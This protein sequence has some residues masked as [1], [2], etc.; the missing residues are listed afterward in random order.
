MCDLGIVPLPNIPDWRYQCPLK[1]IEYLS[2]EKPVVV[3]DIPANR[4]VTGES[5]FAIY[6]SSA[7]PEEFA[8]AIKY[9]YDNRVRLEEAGV[10]GREIIE[11][12]YNWRKIAQEFEHYLTKLEHD[13]Q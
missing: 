10:A 2:M 4:E 13:P 11:D 12:R 9:A 7:D 8:K 5:D 6:V 1:L 3:T